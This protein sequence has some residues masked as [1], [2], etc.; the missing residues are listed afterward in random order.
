M[1][2]INGSENQNCSLFNFERNNYF[3]GKLLTVRDFQLEQRY[4]I[5][6]HRLI[7]RLIVGYGIVCGLEV[8]KV[9]LVKDTL[10]I[11]L[12]QGLALDDCGREIVVS[13]TKSQ[14]LTVGERGRNYIYIEFKERPK[15]SVL[16]DLTNVSSS[17]EGSDYT[18]IEEIYSISLS[19]EAPPAKNNESNESEIQTTSSQ[20]LDELVQQYYSKYLRNCSEGKH[21]KILLAVVEIPQTNG[22]AS[23]LQEET[24]QHRKMV[25]TNPMLYQLLGE[26]NSRIL[27]AGNPLT[28]VFT[29]TRELE[30]ETD[31]S[32]PRGSLVPVSVTVNELKEKEP[33]SVILAPIL[34]A[35]IPPISRPSLAQ[36]EG[37]HFVFGSTPQP[38]R[39]YVAFVPQPYNKTFEIHG[40]EPSLV[41]KQQ[42]VKV[43]YWVIAGAYQVNGSLMSRAAELIRSNPEGITI[44]ALAREL[45]VDSSTLEPELTKL[46]EEGV[47][48]RNNRNRFRP[49]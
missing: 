5:N 34:P 32:L 4:G 41:D 7:N 18:R 14:E 21:N 43:V 38:S 12:T 8:Q 44:T 10:T 28:R 40:F 48:Q 39:T 19:T 1:A 36:Q 11:E 23:L 46:L 35:D 42:K 29:G 30:F 45:G 33:F 24:K 16:P 17:V 49:S 15:E 3:Y 25:Y 31:E 9:D 22:K 26:I 2:T 13:Q 20:T 27:G 37:I 6:K 47:I